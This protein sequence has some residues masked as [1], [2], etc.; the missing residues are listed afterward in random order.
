V[1]SY[2]ESL[3]QAGAD[4]VIDNILELTPML[5]NDVLFPADI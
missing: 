1:P 4:R 5:I 2:R 3:M